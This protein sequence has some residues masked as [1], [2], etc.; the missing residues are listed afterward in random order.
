M[1]DGSIQCFVYVIDLNKT[2]LDNKKMG[3]FKISKYNDILN[4][5][6]IK[7]NLSD[8]KA[9]LKVNL[10]VVLP[11]LLGRVSRGSLT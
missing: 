1:N 10:A 2:I 11:K 9:V 6:L 7:R 3:G 8:L 5:F 4:K